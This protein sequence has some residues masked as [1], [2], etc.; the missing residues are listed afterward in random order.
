M[1]GSKRMREHE[2]TIGVIG[3]GFGRGL[4][5]SAARAGNEAR[6]YTRRSLRPV[7]LQD[8]REVA[9]RTTEDLAELGDSE[10]I[11]LAVPSEYTVSVARQL[12]E[13]VDG[14]H[15]IVHVS[16]GLV[17]DDLQTVSEVLKRETAVRRVGALAGPLASSVLV[18]GNPGGA[19]VGTDFPEV[20]AA[21]RQAIG[22]ERLRIYETP[23]RIGVEVGSALTGMLLFALGYAQGLG[24]G[25]PT[26]GVLASRGVSEVARI[27]RTLGGEIETL[28][29][30][31]CLG[32]LV[33]AVGGDAR[34]EM[35]LGR[36]MAR[37]LSLDDAL[38]K[39]G[40]HIESTHVAGRLVRYAET[41]DVE[42]PITRAI[43][44]VMAG[45]LD[46][47]QAVVA[48]MGRRVGRE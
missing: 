22:N 4:A 16:R 30:L 35:E 46:S 24:F 45:E 18:D 36:A 7:T 42:L 9:L 8:G 1:D 48:L 32:D 44:Q 6:V 2:M 15:L 20:A 31:A 12:A 41:I 37:G 19:I 21:V 17:G 10:L 14:R 33:S 38:A 43:T 5:V 13:H 47:T 11:F 27:A 25:A 3:A 26:I 23:D 29:G 28:S 34:P 39:V 40:A